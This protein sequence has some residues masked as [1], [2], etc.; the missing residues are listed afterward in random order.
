MTDAV[1]SAGTPP[2]PVRAA[3]RDLL[4][5]S[6]HVPAARSR[7]PRDVAKGLVRIGAA[8][9]AADDTAP[10]P[11][12]AP[13]TLVRAQNA[14]S[15]FSGVAAQKVAGTTQQI[16]NAVSFPRFVTELITGVFKAMV[17]SNQQQMNAYVELIK[18]VAA[19]TEGFADANVGA[20]GARQWLVDRFPR[21]GDRRRG[22]RLRSRARTE[23]HAGGAGRARR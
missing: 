7:R 3:I 12:P 1:A 16:L 5:S 20:Q 11:P 22:R 15:S 8:A 18:N 6:E 9:L 13:A 14:G 2:G 19:S 23:A 10:T 17:D 21:V 4:L